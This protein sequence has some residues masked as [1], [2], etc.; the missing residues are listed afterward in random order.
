LLHKPTIGCAM[1][2]LIGTHDE[3]ADDAGSYTNL[4][5]STNSSAPRS[6]PATASIR[7]TFSVG[8]KINLPTALD[9][10][11]E[12]CRGYRLRQPTRMAHYAPK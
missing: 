2:R 6:A 3:P 9:L 1:S 12:A 11:L 7:T 4:E 10:V 5:I 8:H